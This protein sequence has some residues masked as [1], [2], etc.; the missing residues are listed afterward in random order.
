MFAAAVKWFKAW[1]LLHVRGRDS[2]V[3]YASMFVMGGCGLAYEYTLSKLASDLLGNSTMQ[4]AIIIGVM[5]FF[6]GVGSDVQKLLSD[7]RLFDKFLWAEM[8]LGVL[9]AFG[10]LLLLWTYARFPMQYSVVQYGLISAIGLIIGME[11]PLLTRLNQAFTTELKVNL[12]SVLKMDYVGALAGALLWIF[13][14]PRFFT[15]VETA[16]VLGVANIAVAIAALIHFRKLV[17]RPFALAAM[18]VLALAGIGFS[19]TRAAAWSVA[20]EQHLYQDRVVYSHTTRYQHIV[21]T[22]SPQGRVS[23][24]LNGNLQFRSS[25]EFIYHENLVHPAMLIAPRR[26]RVLIMGGGD[27]LALREVLKYPDVR[28]VVLCDLD[29]EMTRLARENELLVRMNESS[30]SDARLVEFSNGALVPAGTREVTTPDVKHRYE[31][32][33]ETV[34]TVEV[35]NVDAAKFIEQFEGSFDVIIAD[36]PDP[37]SLDL[38]RLYSKGLYTHVLGRLSR[39]GVFVQQSTSPFHAKEAF[40]CIG[41]TMRASGLA[42]VPYHDNVPSF[43]EWGWWIAGHAGFVDEAG[44]RRRLEAVREVPVP[45]HYLSCETIRASLLWGKGALE[46]EN[47]DINTLTRDRLFEY[48]QQSWLDQ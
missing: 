47:D 27:G 12:G 20:A 42:P 44:L 25:D 5:M 17:K 30:L 46:S 13:L 1:P 11:I 39:D 28:E 14:L 33:T 24:Y 38:S 22:E 21:L 8:L 26:A 15:V 35:L 4:W 32:S 19:L 37:N 36:F 6:M 3:L 18:A 31:L 23:C 7:S 40:L 29:P 41:R 10:P 45:V 9:G 2:L 34:A 43:G 48:Y 16:L